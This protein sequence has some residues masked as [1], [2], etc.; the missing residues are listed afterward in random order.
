MITIFGD[1]RPFSVQKI[2]VFLNFHCYGPIFGRNKRQ[3]LPT[4]GR[5]GTPARQ[6]E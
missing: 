6:V 3:F 2:S 5:S 1:F 4:L